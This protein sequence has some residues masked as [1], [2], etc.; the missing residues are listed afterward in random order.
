MCNLGANLCL[1]GLPAQAFE[2]WWRA[3]Q[4]SPINW[5]ILV[6]ISDLYRYFI[7]LTKEGQHGGNIPWPQGFQRDV[8]DG[9]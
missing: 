8:T 2:Y 9:A 3:L 5:D 1:M 7:G 4:L 6:G